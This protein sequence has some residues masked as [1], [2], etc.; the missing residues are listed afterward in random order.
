MSDT[1]LLTYA[2]LGEAIGRSEVAARAMAMRKRWKRVLGNDGRARVAVPVELVERLRAEADARAIAQP[3]DDAD[4]QAD[5]QPDGSS[6][7]RALIA[8]LETRIAEL[9]GRVTELTAE[10]KDNRAAIAS[11]T[12]KAGRSD[13]LEALLDIEKQRTEEWKA[14][15]DR[16]AV[17][18]EKLTAAAETRRS[19][20]LFRRRA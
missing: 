16:F 13:T 10:V 5:T 6:D 1:R 3:D 8:V 15:A 2:E 18:A 4:T 7:A 14:V 9:H 12:E 11:L 19:W 20:W 17:Q